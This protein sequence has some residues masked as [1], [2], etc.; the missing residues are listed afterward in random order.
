LIFW[1]FLVFDFI[2]RYA[3]PISIHIPSSS[4]A[5]GLVSAISHVVLVIHDHEGV[6]AVATALAIAVI[7]I[8]SSTF[9]YST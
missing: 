7:A 2:I 3:E 6:V 8:A 1:T 4:D 9:P 5:S